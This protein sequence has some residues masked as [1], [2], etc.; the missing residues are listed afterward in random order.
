MKNRNLP[1]HYLKLAEKNRKLNK[2]EH[3]KEYYHNLVQVMEE[4][5]RKVNEEMQEKLKQLEKNKSTVLA[6]AKSKSEFYLS[7]VQDRGF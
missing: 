1:Y 2:A 6:A 5:D 3:D 7:D 4:K